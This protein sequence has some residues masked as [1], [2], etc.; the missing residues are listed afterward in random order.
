MSTI[1]AQLWLRS[2]GTNC[3]YIVSPALKCNS[4]PP[5]H[6]LSDSLCKFAAQQSNCDCLNKMR[7]AMWGCVGSSPRHQKEGKIC[8]IMIKEFIPKHLFYK[9]FQ[10]IW[11]TEVQVVS[12]H[13]GTAMTAGHIT[14]PW[15]TSWHYVLFSYL[16]SHPS[17]IRMR[18]DGYLLTPI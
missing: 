5:E 6:F 13:C 7:I 12:G 15:I 17:N 18:T 8:V 3:R 14:S 2:D 9:S 10:Y 4:I 11:E 1:S 16:L